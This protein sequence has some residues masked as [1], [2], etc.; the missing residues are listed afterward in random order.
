M[1]VDFSGE[2]TA[3]SCLPFGV[4]EH[5]DSP[6]FANMLPLYAKRQFKPAWFSPSDVKAHAESERI[7]ATSAADK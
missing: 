2:T 4:S 6:Y 1:I 7:L 3:I 5:P